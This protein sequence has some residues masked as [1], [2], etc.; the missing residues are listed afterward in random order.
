MQVGVHERH[1]LM[2]MEPTAEERL[3]RI[4]EVADRGLRYYATAY[5]KTDAAEEHVIAERELL[6]AYM[7]ELANV[8]ALLEGTDLAD[9]AILR[10][11]HGVVSRYVEAAEEDPWLPPATPEGS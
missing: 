4:R 9:R 2:E 8:M 10:V 7:T 5:L 3:A 6:M 1:M 11:R